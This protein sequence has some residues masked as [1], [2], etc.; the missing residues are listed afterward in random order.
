MAKPIGAKTRIIREAITANPSLG[1]KELAA[2]LMSS[3]AR[4]ADGIKV[5]ASDVGDQRTAMRKLAGAAPARRN[6]GGRPK[7]AV[8]APPVREAPAP[9][10]VPVA[11]SAQA[12]PIDLIDRVFMLADDC[13]GMAALKRLVDRLAD[14]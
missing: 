12:S 9:A 4:K 8:Q 3:D 2:L 5:S 10:A 11:R 7:K 1:S 14:R 6:K 13:G